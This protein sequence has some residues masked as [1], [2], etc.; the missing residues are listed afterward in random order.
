MPS[1]CSSWSALA[2][3]WSMVRTSSRRSTS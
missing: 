3:S 2:M 1:N